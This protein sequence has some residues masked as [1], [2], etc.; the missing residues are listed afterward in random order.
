M[1]VRPIRAD[2]FT[3]WHRLFSAYAGLFRD[4][5]SEEHA[6]LVWGWITRGEHQLH[7][8]VVTDDSDRPVGLAHVRWIA[9]P[10]A[11]EMGLYLEDLVIDPDVRAQGLGRQLLDGVAEFA[12]A[13]GAPTVR[14]ITAPDNTRARA[15]YAQ[16]AEEA[17]Y[18]IYDRTVEVGN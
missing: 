8:L 16:V 7:A 17:P 18:I 4:G 6:A 14:W 9:R 3:D 13:G 2:E 15:L 1:S 5:V 12:R 10:L 11:G